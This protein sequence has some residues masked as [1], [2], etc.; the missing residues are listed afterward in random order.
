MEALALPAHKV[1]LVRLV[2][3]AQH[4]LLQALLDLRVQLVPRVLR[5][6][7]VRRERRLHSRVKSPQSVIYPVAQQLM[8]PT[9]SLPMA[10]YT[11]G[12]A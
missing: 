3:L 4:R 8:T 6:R 7:R 10:T 9:S 11:F 2:L 5:V 1:L 12:T